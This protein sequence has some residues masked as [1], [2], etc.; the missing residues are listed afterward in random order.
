[1]GALPPPNFNMKE[2][3]MKPVSTLRRQ[4]CTIA[5]IAALPAAA[6]AQT[7]PTKPIRII[8]PFAAGGVT[9]VVIR[10]IAPKLGEA[11]GQPIIVDNRGGAGGTIGTALGAKSAPDGYTLIAPAASHTTT[12]GLY[13]NLPFDVIKDF[14]P[15]TQVVVVPFMLV[16]HPSVPATNVKELL[17]H[18]RANPNTLNFGSAGNGSSNH[19]AGELLK[20]MGGVEM[21][22]VPYKGSGPAMNDLL[23]G[24][25]SFMFDTINTSIGHVRAGT[26]RALAIGSQK[27]SRAL[28]EVPTVADAADLPG[29]EA[30]TWTG[31]LA[32]AGT[33]PEIITRLNQ[34]V[35]KVLQIPEI[36]QKLSAQGAEPVG[37]SPQEFDAYIRSEIAKWN[38]VIKDA[39]V[40]PIN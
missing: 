32:P 34:E 18:A 28:P 25:L 23:A 27:P 17:A 14:A 1:M 26:L 16:V 35:V 4:L 3:P 13:Q 10:T 12:P 5:L 8:I 39:G 31:L 33:P 21:V 2:I 7:Y 20:S 9:D 29:F 15:I 30:V 38:K 37:S 11:L 22:H 19:L 24:H 6:S 36:Q 40:Q